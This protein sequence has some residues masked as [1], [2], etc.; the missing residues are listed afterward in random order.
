MC[1]Y[2][3]AQ[4]LLVLLLF[5]RTMPQDTREAIVLN[6]VTENKR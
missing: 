1:T 2:T 3:F 6:Q 4:M 5:K